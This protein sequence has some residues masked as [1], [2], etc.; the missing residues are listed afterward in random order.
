MDGYKTKN[1]KIKSI[2]DK[3]MEQDAGAHLVSPD[4]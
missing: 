2:V 1:K 4:E 3:G